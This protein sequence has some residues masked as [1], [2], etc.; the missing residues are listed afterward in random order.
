MDVSDKAG[1]WVGFM[2]GLAFV[3]ELKVIVGAVGCWA[4]AVWAGA[5]AAGAAIGWVIGV[6]A[7]RVT[8]RGAT[9]SVD[10]VV[11]TAEAHGFCWP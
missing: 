10:D 11:P 3:V 6:A 1:V 4:G 2:A 8:S 5:V 7:A 9:A